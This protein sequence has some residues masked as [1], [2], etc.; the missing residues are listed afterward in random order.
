MPCNY[1][2]WASARLGAIKCQISVTLTGHALEPQ[3]INALYFSLQRKSLFTR[4]GPLGVTG[5]G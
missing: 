4:V 1:P 2:S 5:G 3:Y